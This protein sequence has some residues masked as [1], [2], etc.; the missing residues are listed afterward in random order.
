MSTQHAHQDSSTLTRNDAPQSLVLI[1]N[2]EQQPDT[3]KLPYQSVEKARFSKQV[4][5][6]LKRLP[7][8]FE[9]IHEQNLLVQPGETPDE[10]RVRPASHPLEVQV[11]G[12]RAA[13]D[14]QSMTDE[15]LMVL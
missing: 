2:T 12:P 3:E 13:K 1:S 14:A 9:A 8:R 11:V 5:I 6:R 4:C 15:K 7:T 10:R